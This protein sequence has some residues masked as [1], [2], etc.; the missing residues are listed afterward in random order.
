MTNDKQAGEQPPPLKLSRTFHAPR[1]IVFRAWSSADHIKRWF[2]PEACSV[3]EAEVDMRAGGLFYVRMCCPGD[4]DH[5]SR[6][7]F[8]EVSPH[9]RLALDLSVTD[10]KDRALFRAYTE[11]DFTDV[12]G[13][14]RMDVTQ[15]YTFENPTEASYFTS[16]APQ[17]WAQ[18]LDKLDAELARMW[19]KNDST[20]P[21]AAHSIFTIERTYDSPVERLFRAFSDMTAKSKWFG[22]DP[23]RL[24]ILEREMDFRVGGRERLKGRW[25]GGVTS[26]FDAIYHDIIPNQRIIYTYEM[27]LDDRKISVSLATVE[28]KALG[29]NRASLKVTE[30]GVFLD[31]Y[32]DAGSRER[33]TNFLLDRIA[34]SLA[35][36]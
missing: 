30:Q 2:A 7:H 11:V 24:E 6:G 23:G 14:T 20:V 22:G 19:Y 21:G 25:E 17:G 33:G 29:K 28:M 9:D 35:E 36:D 16:L 15:T 5:R 27:H 10:A 32:E 4:I 26:T 31:G 3:P 12:L 34:T 18:T 1:E 13:G 8:A